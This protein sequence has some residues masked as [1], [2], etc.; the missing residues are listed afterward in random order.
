MPS[1]G[2]SAR[3]VRTVSIPD[4]HRWC[5]GRW[6]VWEG[7]GVCRYD[8]HGV[9]TH[10]IDTHDDD[11]HDDDTNGIDTHT[12][13]HCILC[14]LLPTHP[15]PLINTIGVHTRFRGQPG[16]HVDSG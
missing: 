5:V 10:G 12:R 14:T 15:H 4:E 3:R 2:T 1:V 8:A 6:C 9:H 7:G 11:T 13:A 16:E